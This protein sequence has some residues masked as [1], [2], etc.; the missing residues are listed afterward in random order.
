MNSLKR[1]ILIALIQLTIIG[2]V[3]FLLSPYLFPQHITISPK[4]PEIHICDQVLWAGEPV[5][6]KAAVSGMD[7]PVSYVWS[8]DNIPVNSTGEEFNTEFQAGSHSITIM[9]S[10]EINSLHKQINID[11]VTS[12]A[13]L[14]V[15]PE[16]SNTYG[17][18]KFRTFVNNHSISVPGTQV[19]MGD[20][21]NTAQQCSPASVKGVSAGSYTWKAMYHDQVIGSGIIE[22]PEMY[23]LQVVSVDIKPEYSAGDTISSTLVVTNTG[24]MDIAG[25]HI[26]ALVLNHKFAVMGDAAQRE[27][28]ID[29]SD[30]LLPGESAKLPI[31]VSIPEKVQGIRPTGRYTIKLDLVSGN[32]KVSSITLETQVV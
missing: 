15:V 4:S 18:W 29:H 31:H 10:N 28:R 19:T 5:T 11:A 1:N 3:M 14:R 24:T 9:A 20:M 23:M 22:V 8:I 17:T 26:N 6:L 32:S 25:F 16:H 30:T 2:S 13:G 12:T 7:R 27:F 21:K